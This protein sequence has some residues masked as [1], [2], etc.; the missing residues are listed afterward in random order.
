M[1][2]FIG[3]SRENPIDLGIRVPTFPLQFLNPPI[4]QSPDSSD[5]SMTQWPDHPIIQF[6]LNS[7]SVPAWIVAPRQSTPLPWRS[8]LSTSARVHHLAYIW[9]YKSRKR[10][11]V[12]PVRQ[13][14]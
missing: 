14:V 8:R 3:Y 10:Q 11:Q 1:H 5:S 6:F 4:P 2:A 7:S 13:P 9:L 12:V